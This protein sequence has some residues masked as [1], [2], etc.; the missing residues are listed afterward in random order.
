MTKKTTRT[1]K[2]TLPALAALIKPD[3][4]TLSRRIDRLSETQGQTNTS[5]RD[6]LNSLEQ[7]LAALVAE[8]AKLKDP[9]ADA[10]RLRRARDVWMKQA[11][12]WKA[13]AQ[14]RLDSN[15]K[16]NA[17]LTEER[18]RLQRILAGRDQQLKALRQQLEALQ[19]TPMVQDAQRM[20]QLVN[21]VQQRD[22]E[23]KAAHAREVAWMNR[24]AE[25]ADRVEELKLLRSGR[26]K[27]GTLKKGCE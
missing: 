17:T 5:I 10:E 27:G 7:R 23:L 25:A 21:E 18:E 13:L 12:D 2:T 14:Q 3:L 9:A 4:D 20:A 8:V 6:R 24:Y 11:D 19:N 1:I 16:L 15:E 26:S 22:S